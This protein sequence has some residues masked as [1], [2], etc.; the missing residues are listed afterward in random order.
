[1]K[2]DKDLRRAAAGRFFD[3]PGIPH[4]GPGGETRKSL[5]QFGLILGQSLSLEIRYSRMSFPYA[6]ILVEKH[7]TRSR[8]L[9]LS[10]L[11][12][13]WMAGKARNSQEINSDELSEICASSYNKSL[14]SAHKP[15]DAKELRLRK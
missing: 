12:Q 13:T 15:F 8:I 9:R 14:G 6:Q 2:V 7:V 10:I 11:T 4:F 5:V 1:M 3:F